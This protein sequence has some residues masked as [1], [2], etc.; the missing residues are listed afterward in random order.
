M[1]T[2]FVQQATQQL[3]P[4]YD[5][6]QKAEEARIPQIQKLYDSLVGGLEQQRG[7]ETQNILESASQRG[8]LRSTLPVDLQQDLGRQIL[9]TRGQYD[10][11][12]AG[13]IA[14]VYSNIGNLRLQR[15]TGIQSLADSLQ[16]ADLRERD[17]Q[18]QSAADRASRAAASQQN[19]AL[20]YLTSLLGG[21]QPG[22]TPA[23]ANQNLS[24]LDE[25]FGSA[26]PQLRVAVGNALQQAGR[27][28]VQP[29]ATARTFQP[30]APAKR[31]KQPRLQGA[32]AISGTLR[33]R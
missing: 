2:R 25:I 6:Q 11:Q 8:V 29:A 20:Q 18:R 30:A 16:A 26:A 4:I 27:V 22:A 10:L 31:T 23:T 1:A 32:G 9:Q 33:V 19:S 7:I 12:R 21:N 5:Q 15:A 28:N 14:D 17:F 3:A 13:D 24:L